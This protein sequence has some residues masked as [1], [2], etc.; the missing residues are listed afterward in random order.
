MKQDLREALPKVRNPPSFTLKKKQWRLRETGPRYS[1]AIYGGF[2][3]LV[4]STVLTKSRKT[5][6]FCHKIHKYIS[7]YGRR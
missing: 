2:G 6:V 1:I 3:V 5:A 7:Q 4:D